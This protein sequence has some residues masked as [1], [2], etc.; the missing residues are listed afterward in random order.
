[1]KESINLNKSNGQGDDA[2][3]SNNSSEQGKDA[4]FSNEP[5][6]YIYQNSHRVEL[7]RHDIINYIAKNPNSTIYG[8]AKGVSMAYNLCHKAM[9]ELVFA[10]LVCVKHGFDSQGRNCELF[11]IPKQAEVTGND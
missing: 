1:M 8:I 9:K 5:I 2:L 11:F 6:S 10:R 4:F 3:K 7:K